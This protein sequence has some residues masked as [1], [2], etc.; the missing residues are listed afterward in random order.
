MEK[1]EEIETIKEK[2]P[3]LNDIFGLDEWD[4]YRA[5]AVENGYVISEISPILGEKEQTL[6]QF[7]LTEKK[8]KEQTYSQKRAAE[9]P[10]VEEQLDM[11]YWDKVNQTNKW[12]ETISAIKNK[13]PKK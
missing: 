6:R 5:F 10:S 11:I 8:E 12:Q 7:Q 4:I 2:E 1:F 9:Y 13:Y 3:K